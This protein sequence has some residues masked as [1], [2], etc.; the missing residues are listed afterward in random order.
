[1]SGE[2]YRRFGISSPEPTPAMADRPVPTNVTDGRSWGDDVWA[3]IRGSCATPDAAAKLSA[4]NFCVSV[5]AEGFGSLPVVLTDPAGNEVS[6]D[7]LGELLSLS[8]NPLQTAAEFWASMA[9]RAAL[10]GHAFAEPVMTAD[11]LNLWSLPPDRYSVVWKER[12]FAVSYAEEGAPARI[13]G[14]NDLFWF[15]GLADARLQPLTPWRMAKGSI[16]FAL[17]LEEQGRSF[18]QNQQRLSGLLSTE[19]RMNPEVREATEQS[20]K[21]WRS[22]QT[23]VLTGGLKY[24]AV[25]A[26]NVESQLL[27]LIKQRTLEMARYWRIPRSMVGEDGGTAASQEQQALEFVK[28][29]I[30]PWVR[31]IEQAVTVRL[32]TPDQRRR[33]RVKFNLDGLLRGDSATQWRNAVMARTASLISVNELRVK[34]FGLPR[35]EEDWADDVRLPLNSNHAGDTLSGGETA[36]QN[37]PE[38]NKN[39]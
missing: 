8:P 26:A 11:G 19:Q 5:I 37:D 32:M 9:Y 36:P 12:S 31:R 21:H 24:Q 17:A 3:A 25:T 30:R 23:P 20:M 7:P 34:W 29:T 22:G 27:E 35:I 4:V 1:M 15:S 18:F 38:G 39:G 6:D 2:Q 10:A 28:Y 13:M 14:P 16:E 33:L